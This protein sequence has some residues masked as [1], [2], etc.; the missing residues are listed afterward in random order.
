M[1][2]LRNYETI[3]VYT[4]NMHMGVHSIKCRKG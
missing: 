3:I 1:Q 4:E 2:R